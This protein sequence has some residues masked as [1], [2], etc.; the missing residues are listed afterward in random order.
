MSSWFLNGCCPKGEQNPLSGPITH[1]SQF[2]SKI[3]RPSKFR[4]NTSKANFWT[5]GSSTACPQ[6]FSCNWPI[7]QVHAK[8][9]EGGGNNQRDRQKKETER[10]FFWKGIYLSYSVQ[11]FCNPSK[12]ENKHSK[13]KSFPR[14]S[15]PIR[16]PAD[17]FQSRVRLLWRGR[18]TPKSLSM[19]TQ[20]TLDRS[21]T[22]RCLSTNTQPRSPLFR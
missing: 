3:Q 13:P 5:K 19:E 15:G 2:P 11:P 22:A 14:L 16:F 9:L 12:S 18:Q 10:V 4:L 8:S 20:K 1:I 17:D 6:K 21:W 7:P